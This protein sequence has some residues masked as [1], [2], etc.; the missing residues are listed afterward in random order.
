MPQIDKYTAGTVSA[1]NGGTTF[2]GVGTAWVS[3]GTNYVVL[4]GYWMRIGNYVGLITSVNSNGTQLTAVPPYTGPNASGLTYEIFRTS[5]IADPAVRGAVQYV[6]ERGG[7][8]QPFPG[9]YVDGG[10][11]RARLYDAGANIIALAVGASGAADGALVNAAT[12]NRSA[13]AWS[14]TGDLTV[15]GSNLRINGTG[16]FLTMT[17]SAGRGWRLNLTNSGSS[18]G[19]LNFET[20]LDNWATVNTTPYIITA[21]GNATFASDVNAGRNVSATNNVSVGNA[22]TVTGAATLNGGLTVTSGGINVSGTSSIATTG[23]PTGFAIGGATSPIYFYSG[24]AADQARQYWKTGD[25]MSWCTSTSGT[26]NTGTVVALTVDANYAF[27]PGR[28][29]LQTCGKI[30]FRW[31]QFVAG[32]TTIATSDAREKLVR[33]APTEAELDAWGDVHV[34]AYQFLDA[35]ETKGEEYARHHFGWTAQAIEAAFAARGLDASRY[36]LFCRD[37]KVKHLT[38]TVVRQRQKEVTVTE[39][40]T[41]VEILDGL[42]VQRV[43]TRE[44]IVPAT[45]EQ[46]VTDEAGAPVL[47]WRPDPLGPDE[48]QDGLLLERGEWLAVTYPVPVMEEYEETEGYEEPDGDRLGLRYDECQCLE[49]AW[50]RRE[51]DRRAAA[52]EALA[53]RLDALEAAA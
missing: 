21:T 18:V 22:L 30:G 4:A 36:A 39:E 27:S 14:L 15:G 13:P 26:S 42:P 23:G 1:T 8:N 53:D 35:V 49:I 44:V 5:N 45:V 32:T 34:I 17:N 29:N 25:I 38:R 37:E 24:S 51:N 40:V 12:Y 31:A 50:L 47:R 11:S 46:P 19:V 3:G 28:D 10:A 9:V 43:V 16:S 33:G 48:R 41:V 52:I 7:A 20:T 6:L 2:N